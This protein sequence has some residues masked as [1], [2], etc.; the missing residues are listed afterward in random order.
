MQSDISNGKRVTAPGG[1]R[2]R[3]SLLKSCNLDKTRQF[4]PKGRVKVKSASGS[5]TEP[6]GAVQAFMYGGCVRIP[7]TFQRADKRIDLPC[8]GILGRDFLA[9]A[10]AKICYK[11]GILTLGPGSKKIHKVLSPIDNKNQPKRIQRLVV[12]RRAEIL[13]GLSV[14]VITRNDEGHMENQEIREGCISQGQLLKYRQDT[15]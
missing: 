9:H 3:V 7:F 12:P 8:G 15:R 1:H 11:T 13:V 6:M 5:T 14:E 4:D 10:G 2:R